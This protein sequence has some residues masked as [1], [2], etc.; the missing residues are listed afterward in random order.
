MTTLGGVELE[1]GRP[2]DAIATFERA[3]ALARTF[4]DDPDGVLATAETG[5]GRA[6]V[7][8]ARPRDAIP[9]LEAGLVWREHQSDTPP[10]RLGTP[11]WFL[12]QALWLGGGGRARSRVLAQ[13]AQADF[14]RAVAEFRMMPG[15]YQ[16]AY[17][18]S[19][20]L[21]DDVKAWRVTH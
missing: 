20:I 12:A 11:R 8:F 16:D 9:H 15:P 17:K 6:L 7:L 14:E 13:Q 18:R 21:L 3:A 1:L 4:P 10:A 2:E 19:L 5:L